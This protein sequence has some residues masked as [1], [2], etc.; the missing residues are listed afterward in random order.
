MYWNH[1]VMQRVDGAGTKFE[2][3]NYYIVEVYY[4]EDGSILGWSEKEDVM[5]DS[6]EGIRQ[7]L[8]WMQESLLKPILI[9]AELLAKAEK[10]RADGK[11]TPIPEAR[12]SLDEVLNSIGLERKDLEETKHPEPEGKRRKSLNDHPDASQ[13][14]LL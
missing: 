9:E 11:D 8:T 1:R 7:T 12:V 6:V 5:S 14:G 13:G 10:D 3:T 2:E 4:N